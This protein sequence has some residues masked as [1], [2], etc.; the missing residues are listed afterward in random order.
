MAKITVRIILKW[1]S[2][3]SHVNSV[4]FSLRKNANCFMAYIILPCNILMENKRHKTV[5]TFCKYLLHNNLITLNKHNEHQAR[6][7]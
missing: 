2:N 3:N 5:R 7:F 6:Y 1:D 4:V